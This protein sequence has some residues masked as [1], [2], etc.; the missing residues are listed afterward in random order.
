MIIQHE[1]NSPNTR[2]DQ[3]WREDCSAALIQKAASPSKMRGGSVPEKGPTFLK[4]YAIP[5]LLL[6][7]VVGGWTLVATHFVQGAMVYLGYVLIVTVGL[8]LFL[9]Y[10]DSFG[11]CR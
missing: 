4:A 7:L 5:A 6:N 1:S 10:L 11:W 8:R 9:A 2:V 3:S